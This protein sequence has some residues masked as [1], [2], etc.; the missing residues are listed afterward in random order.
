[1]GI[2]IT[3]DDINRVFLAPERGAYLIMSDDTLLITLNKTC[4]A[5]FGLEGMEKYYY[6]K[7]MEVNQPPSNTFKL[8]H[9]QSSD[10]KL[11]AHKAGSE[12]M[13]TFTLGGRRLRALVRR[14]LE[15]NWW[16]IR[17]IEP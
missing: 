15:V 6:L 4:K 3:M 8:S 17:I 10:I 14:I 13:F 5:I 9:H 12:Q 2:D 16:L 1:M 11:F 7:G